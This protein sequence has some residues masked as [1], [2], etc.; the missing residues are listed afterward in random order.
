MKKKKEKYYTTNL[1]TTSGNKL[2]L[3]KEELISMNKLVKKQAYKSFLA[4][5]IVCE[6]GEH[7][8]K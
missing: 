5:K 8:K 1:L 7:I 4:Q 2:K 6:K 3:T